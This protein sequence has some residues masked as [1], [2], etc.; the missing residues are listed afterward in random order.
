VNIQITELFN[1]GYESTPDG[2]AG[3]ATD[4]KGI[5]E[6]AFPLGITLEEELKPLENESVAV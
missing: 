4:P 2:P 1:P 5:L 3:P 6:L